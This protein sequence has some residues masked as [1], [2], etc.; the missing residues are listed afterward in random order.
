MGVTT[1]RS[2]GYRT[3]LMFPLYDG[4]VIDRGEY[5]VVRTPSNP[6]YYWGNF[7]LFRLP[8]EGGAVVRWRRLFAE[9]IG[10]RFPSHHETFG[11]DNPEG[12]R[13]HIDGFVKE[14][15]ELV[16]S[17]VLTAQSVVPPPRVAA[18]LVIRPMESEADWNEAIDFGTLTRP[19]G[20]A[21]A[22][23]REFRQRQM[24]RYRAMQ[25]DGLGYWFGAFRSGKLLADV[26][27]FRSDDLARYQSVVT[28]PEHRRQGVA[29]TLVFQASVLFLE[30]H[31]GVT[32]VI[33]AEDGS[34]AE[35][36]YRSI[37]FQPREYQLGLERWDRTA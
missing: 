30:Q 18:D 9:E 31:P 3:D 25:A 10:A 7:L 24:R 34:G 17:R 19:E 4:E 2:L 14:G 5:I 33:V 13:G 36:L 26:G 11:W 23:Y 21:D 16:A 8:P 15:F 37:G 27:L 1:L 6:T 22:G 12:E 32:L 28:H 29:G 35:R 20:H